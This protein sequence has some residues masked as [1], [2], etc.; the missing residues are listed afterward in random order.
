MRVEDF[1]VVSAN[2]CAYILGVLKLA[3]DC[4][5]PHIAS[6]KALIYSLLKIYRPH[7]QQRHGDL[8]GGP[9]ASDSSPTLTRQPTMTHC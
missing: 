3:Q 2:I 4:C 5:S 6:Q 8:C 9:S 7:I 1:V